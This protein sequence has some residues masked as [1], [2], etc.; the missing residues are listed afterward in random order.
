[1]L[2]QV[3]LD[4][5]ETDYFFHLSVLGRTVLLEANAVQHTIEVEFVPVLAFH[6]SDDLIAGQ[7]PNPL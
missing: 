2:H 5:R 3:A 7:M 1:L 4:L 6:P